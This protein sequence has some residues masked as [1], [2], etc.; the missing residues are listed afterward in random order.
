MKSTK[1]IREFSLWLLL[2]CAS[3]GLAGQETASAKTKDRTLPES[4]FGERR[5][6]KSMFG[7]AIGGHWT[8]AGSVTSSAM[9]NNNALPPGTLA[10]SQD[11]YVQQFGAR[12]SVSRFGKK[13]RYEAHYMPE[14][15]YYHNLSS[16]NSMSHSFVQDVAFRVSEALDIVWTLDG[17]KFASN[18]IIGGLYAGLPAVTLAGS[19]LQATQQNQDV[20]N[21][22]TAVA[23]LFR[24]GAANSFSLRLG[25]GVSQ[26][27]G[28]NVGGAT[29]EIQ[30]SHTGS[31][32]W[33][34]TF[35]GGRK[36]FGVE[37]TQSYFG[38]VGPNRHQQNQTAKLRYSQE[39]PG[40]LRA[41]I[42]AGPSFT[43]AQP[44]GA[45]RPDLQI[46]WAVDGSLD[47]QFEVWGVGVS[48]IHGEQLSLIQE[49]VTTDQF[50][51][52]VSRTFGR[53]KRW[54]TSVN[55]G[56][57]RSKRPIAS[58]YLDGATGNFVLGY[59]INRNLDFNASYTYLHQHDEWTVNRFGKV[60]RH[61]AS[62]GFTY[63]FGP[64]QP[65]TGR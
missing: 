8:V 20:I 39:L 60:N 47:R 22:N 56:F 23:F 9:W 21:S 7:E 42:G 46:S 54:N 6:K 5:D 41:S 36:T 13:V 17:R 40:R 31:L 2:V 1:T 19:N 48:Y 44:A 53:Q 51:A 26:F 4:P 59:R 61:Q 58:G 34:H 55:A 14:Y 12:V 18:Q 3:S 49:S 50:S 43:Q 27:R 11:D 45:A 10:A 30:Y 29:A 64:F 28:A 63:N 38:F 35:S 33:T 52:R 16:Q 15:S 37:A 24:P 65:G 25:S 62:A 32:G 57:T